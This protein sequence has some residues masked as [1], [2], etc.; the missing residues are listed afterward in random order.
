MKANLQDGWK[1]ETIGP[2]SVEIP[3]DWD[4]VTLNDVSDNSGQ[5]GANESAQEFDKKEFRYIRITDISEKGILKNADKQSIPIDGNEKYRLEE[6]DLLFART[7]SVG[8][9]YLYSEDDSDVPCAFAGYLIRYKINSNINTEYLKQYTDSRYFDKWVNSIARSTT[10][11]NI[12][13]SEY[14]SLDIPYPP[15]PEQQRIADILSTVDK[16]IQQTDEII[17]ETKELKR[18]L[19]QDLYVR[20]TKHDRET[21]STRIGEIPVSWDLAIMDKC[22]EVIS[23]THVKSALVS[24]DDSLTPYITGPSDF[25]RTGIQVSKYTN[26]PSS[27]CEIGD[28]LVTVKGMSCGKSTFADS[29]VSISRQLKAIRPGTD[30]DEKYLFYWIRY[31]EQLLYV[32]AEGTRQLGLSTSDLTTLPIPVPPF[33]EQEEI[34]RILSEIDKKISQEIQTKQDLE[35]LKRGLMQDLLTGKVRVSTD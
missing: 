23:G 15:L 28:T 12:N 32:L 10:H 22:A 31:K 11:A 35:G 34:G 13:A 30:L 7:G 6:G 26:S 29:A 14:S 24:D 18:G 27:F 25:T 8:R 33:E 19:M 2:V 20:G 5:Y 9:S 3:A 16:Q 1:L 4:M 21:Q 17:Q